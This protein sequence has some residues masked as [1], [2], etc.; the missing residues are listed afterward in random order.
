MQR[1]PT[2]PILRI[3]IRASSQELLYC[4][5]ITTTSRTKNRSMFAA[6]FAE[7]GMRSA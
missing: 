1:S 3:H 4:F 7:D 5:D 2:H 6:V